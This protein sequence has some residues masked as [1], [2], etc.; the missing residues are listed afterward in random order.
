MKILITTDLFTTETNGVVTSIKN[1]WRELLA[2]GHDVRIITL[3]EKA[4]SRKDEEEQVYFVSSSSIGFIYPNVRMPLSYRNAYVKDI[5]E[6]KPDVIHSQ[7]E[8]FSFKFARY[9][10]KKT[11]APIVHTYH[12]MYEDYVNY[13]IPGKKLGKNIVRRFSKEILNRSDTVIAPTK[14]VKDS[15]LRYG[16]NTPI[17]IVPSGI[18]LDQHKVEIDRSAILEKRRTLGISDDASVLV[19]LGRLGTEKN[20]D[21]LIRYFAAVYSTHPKLYLLIVGNGPAKE[22]LEKLAESLGVS[23][24]IIFTGMVRPDEVQ[25]YYRMGDIF[26]SASTSETQGLTYIEAS[27]NGLPLLCRNDPCLDGVIEQGENG[28]AYTTQEEFIDYLDKTITDPEWLQDASRK[29]REIAN[30]FDKSVFGN[31]VEAIYNLVRRK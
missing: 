8:F 25:Y 4:R 2:K 29:S 3:S 22:D 13:V 10:S 6:W 12:T 24:R 11:G 9:I 26:V 16:V 27:A 5:I 21:E 23:D 31:K 18:N 20:V 28:Y 30:T 1:L 14:K 15:L 7:C 19:N 17:E